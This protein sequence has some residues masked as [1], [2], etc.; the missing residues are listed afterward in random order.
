[1]KLQKLFGMVLTLVLTLVLVSSAHAIQV[2]FDYALYRAA[3]QQGIFGCDL[4][5][6][7]KPKIHYLDAV[8]LQTDLKNLLGYQEVSGKDPVA[9]G[10]KVFNTPGFA[11][12]FLKPGDVIFLGTDHVG[13]VVRGPARACAGA[14]CVDH[15]I[16][17]PGHVGDRYSIDPH[18]KD[19]IPEGPIGHDGIFGGFFQADPVEDFLHKRPINKNVRPVAVYRPEKPPAANA[20]QMVCLQAKPPP[21]V[22]TTF[23][24]G[25][26]SDKLTFSLNNGTGTT[27]TWGR[28]TYKNVELPLGPVTVE[29]ETNGNLPAGWQMSVFRTGQKD[30]AGNY[31]RLCYVQ[32]GDTCRGSGPEIVA[33]ERYD[34]HESIFAAVNAPNGAVVLAVQLDVTWKKKK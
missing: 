24:H 1:M 33:D 17:V 7:S 3:Q 32:T 15:F 5:P 27:G 30:A 13:F 28:T 9:F 21:G 6:P 14:V 19:Y 10:K 16:Q 4:D 2:C 20:R 34:A 12:T 18:S 23:L 26:V 8:T 11:E 31:Y 22:V 25:N 29:A